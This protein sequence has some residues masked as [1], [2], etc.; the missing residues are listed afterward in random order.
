MSG[1]PLRKN[2]LLLIAAGKAEGFCFGRTRLYA[3]FAEHAF[4]HSTLFAALHPTERRVLGKSGQGYVFA[5]VNA[6][7]LVQTVTA[8]VVVNTAA[9]V[10]YYLVL[11]RIIVAWKPSAIA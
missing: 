1:K 7:T 4:G 10:V 5:R 2:K 9:Y 6:L 3:Q 11:L 8:L